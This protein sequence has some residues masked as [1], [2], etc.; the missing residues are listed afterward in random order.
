MINV[1]EVKL[2]SVFFFMIF[3]LSGTLRKTFQDYKIFISLFLRTVKFCGFFF[4]HLNL[5]FGCG[6]EQKFTFI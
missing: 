1:Y 4:S 2:S 3:V 6:L 5:Y